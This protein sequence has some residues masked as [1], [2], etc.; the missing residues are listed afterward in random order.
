MISRFVALDLE[1]TGVNP[2]EDKIIEIGMARIVEGEIVESYNQLIN[3]GTELS[4][5]IID[6]TS[7]T[8]LDLIGKPTIKEVIDEVVDFIGEDYILGHNIAFDYSFLKVAAKANNKNIPNKVIDTLKISRKLLSDLPS[9]RLTE[10]CKY[11]NID[12]G[13]SHRAYDDAVSAFRLYEK[14]EAINPKEEL[15]N[16]PEEVFYSIKKTSQI[17]PAQTRFLSSLCSQHGISLEKPIEEFTKSEASKAID[18]ILSTYG[19]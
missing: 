1:T 2:S 11:F 7:I 12:P 13:H 19:R 10:L 8:P 17:T 16:K 15:I 14:L 3:P 4:Q 6:I 5:R 9:R 18:N